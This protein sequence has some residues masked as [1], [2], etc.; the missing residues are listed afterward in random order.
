VG[1]VEG[2]VVA[3]EED[4]AGGLGPA[5]GVDVAQAPP[6]LLQVGL[7]EEGDLAGL[8]VAL[9]H[10]VAQGGQPAGAGGPPLVAGPAGQ[11]GGQVGVADEEP[12]VELG[13]GGV[14]VGAGQGDGLLDRAHRMAQL[15]ATVPDRVPEPLGHLVD[16]AAV[17]AAAP[18]QQDQVEVAARAQLPAPVPAHGH[19][20]Q[21]VSGA[22]GGGEQAG[23]PVVG[24]LGVGPAE[25]EPPQRLVV[26][27]GAEPVSR[28]GLLAGPAVRAGQLA[29]PAFRAGHRRRAASSWSDE[30]TLAP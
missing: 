28:S 16:V 30:I 22:A 21:P 8:G 10:R 12:G 15:Q 3:R 19:Q 1:G 20:G 29:G 24:R 6:A 23:E 11:L 13:G 7:Q 17:A 18:V 27:Y 14:E 5:Q 4:A 2:G 9:G 25:V 26:A